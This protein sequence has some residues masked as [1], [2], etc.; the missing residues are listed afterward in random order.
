MSN[1]TGYIKSSFGKCFCTNKC[2]RNELY[3]HH[4]KTPVECVLRTFSFLYWKSLKA[5]TLILSAIKKKQKT[6]KNIVKLVAEKRLR[7]ETSYIP[8][9]DFLYSPLALALLRGLC[10]PSSMDFSSK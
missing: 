9:Q 4:Y 7:A 10:S 1:K 5:N 6:K 3:D 2:N 8:K